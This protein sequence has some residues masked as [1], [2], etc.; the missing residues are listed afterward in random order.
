MKNSILILFC[1]HSV[2]LFVVFSLLELKFPL[3]WTAP[4]AA[5]YGRFTIK[6]D[7]WSYGILLAEIF[8]Y[9]APPYGS[10]QLI[11]G[12][13]LVSSFYCT[14]RSEGKIV[15]QMHRVSFSLIAC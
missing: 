6:S 13:K 3:K 4:E 10:K 14:G 9:G 15:I 12:T 1:Q 7:V 2:Y 8:S 11:K 5:F